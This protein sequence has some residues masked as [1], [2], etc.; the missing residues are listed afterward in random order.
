MPGT[1]TILEAMP[2]V[3]LLFRLRYKSL[4]DLGH[5]GD[6]GHLGQLARDKRPL[7]LLSHKG[8]IVLYVVQ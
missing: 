4:G 1:S 6:S 8:L 7:S 2:R 5:I 3:T